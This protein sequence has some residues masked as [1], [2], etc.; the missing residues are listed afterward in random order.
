MYVDVIQPQTKNKMTERED[1]QVTK[2]RVDSP[3]DRY[4]SVTPA[5]PPLVIMLMKQMTNI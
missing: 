3:I 1:L 2:K 4:T 5:I